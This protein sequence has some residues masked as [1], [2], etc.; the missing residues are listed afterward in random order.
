MFVLQ[1]QQEHEKGEVT[2]ITTITP[3]VKETQEIQNNQEKS[4]VINI[5]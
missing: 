3:G 5:K 1:P 4:I 2:I